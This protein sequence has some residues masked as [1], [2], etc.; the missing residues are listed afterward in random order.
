MDF[1]R[2]KFLRIW[3]KNARKTQNFL[4]QTLSSLKVLV[5]IYMYWRNYKCVYTKYKF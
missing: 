4:P 2:K 1:L 5:S 3:A